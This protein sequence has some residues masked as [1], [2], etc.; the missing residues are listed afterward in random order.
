MILFLFITNNLK[1]MARILHEVLFLFQC[2]QNQHYEVISTENIILGDFVK[3]TRI[4]V[5]PHPHEYSPLP[6]NGQSLLLMIQVTNTVLCSTFPQQLMV[7]SMYSQFCSHLSIFGKKISILNSSD[8]FL[9]RILTSF[10][11]MNLQ[12]SLVYLG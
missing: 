5:F 4:L 10:F 3:N 12:E 1:P 11:S 8:N 9:N 7:L 2:S 6:D